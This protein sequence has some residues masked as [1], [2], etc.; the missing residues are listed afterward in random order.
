MSGKC[1]GI[2]AKIKEHNLLAVHTVC[3]ILLNHSAV[4]CC[5]EAVSFFGFI[6]ELYD[7]V[8]SLT[9]SW[10][11][12]LDS[13]TP[14]GCP[15]PKSLFETRWSSNAIAANAVFVGYSNISDALEK[16]CYDDT[17]KPSTKKDA[18]HLKYGTI[19]F[20]LLIVPA[21]A[22]KVLKSMLQPMLA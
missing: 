17:Q 15:V 5:F 13:L 6:Q 9:N 16:T 21:N 19:S 2:Q 7:F 3:Y 18:K 11:F 20:S 14:K 12:L 1:N 22:C 10:K 8:S 4:D